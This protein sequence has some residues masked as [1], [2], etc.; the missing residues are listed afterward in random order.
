MHKQQ[1]IKNI[2]LSVTQFLLVG[3]VLF[4]L[5]K[6]LLNKLGAELF[7]VWS[8]VL[9][10]TTFANI[11]NLGFSGSVVK[12]VAQSLAK[13]DVEKVIN[14]IETSAISISVSV[15]IVFL[16]SYPV[17]KWLLRIII[18]N[19]HILEALDI[20]PYA[21]LSLWISVIAGVFQAGL[22][23]HQRIDISSAITI[24]RMVSYLILCLILVPVW[25]LMGLAYAHVIQACM[26]TILSWG[27]LK[28]QIPTLPLI[29]Y[30]WSNKLFRE[31]MGY[32]LNIQ[33]ITI[34]QMLYDPITKVLLVKFGGLDLAGYYEMANRM[35]TQLRG[36]IVAAVQVLVPTI[37]DLKENDPDSI[38]K[39]YKDAYGLVLFIALPYFSA[40]IAMIPVISRMWI[41]YYE[42]S[43]VAFSI[44][45]SFGWF[46][47]TLVTPAY[48]TDLGIG[49]L[50]W[51]TRGHLIMA[52]SNVMLGLVLGYIFGGRGV[53]IAWVLSLVAGSITILLS[54][55]RRNNIQFSDMFPKNYLFV[56]LS[57][58][59]GFSVSLLAYRNL[60]NNLSLMSI[61]GVVIL[62]IIIVPAFPLWQHPMRKRLMD[63][64]LSRLAG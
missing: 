61:T 60:S 62:T 36:M 2:I 56:G 53:V 33:M 23:G 35:V 41:G 22:D 50:T 19:S 10:A 26:L 6:F 45:L 13:N 47:N 64:Q 39:V 51:N 5:Y 9:S 38:H 59:A 8:L 49:K 11:A 18:P 30:R 58:L 48:F 7:G 46:I 43:F 27:M 63:M 21:M 57:S 42:S 14:I 32:G 3:I 17:A 31:M 16:I 54:F 28:R 12:Y 29:P 1:I 4:I 34:S 15:G 20:L 24:L 44:L 25:G 55:H 37:A 40:I 52:I